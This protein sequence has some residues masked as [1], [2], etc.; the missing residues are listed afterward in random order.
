MVNMILNE[1]QLALQ[2]HFAMPQLLIDLTSIMSN[3]NDTCNCNILCSEDELNSD[4][5]I[6]LIHIIYYNYSNNQ[7]HFNIYDHNE[8][9]DH[10]KPSITII[11]NAKS[12][13]GAM[14]Y[15]IVHSSECTM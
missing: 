13:D 4:N 2:Q 15:V 11:I 9:D 12:N 1:N 8:F 5:V 10:Y 7:N 3:T 14:M 6:I